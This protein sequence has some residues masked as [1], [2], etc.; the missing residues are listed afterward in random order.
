MPLTKEQQIIADFYETAGAAIK[1]HL[2]DIIDGPLVHNFIL[3]PTPGAKAIT[4]I[5]AVYE[6]NYIYSYGNQQIIVQIP[7][8]TRQT[9]FL[10]NLLKSKE[11]KNTDATLAIILGTDTFGNITIKDLREIPHVL[12]AGRTGSGKSVFLNCVLK[13]LKTAMPASECKFIIIDPKGVDYD[14]WESDKHL[15]CPIVKLDAKLAVQK[16]RE[17]SELIKE[18][19]QKLQDRKVKNI[20]EYK[21]KTKN[22]DM[23]YV[24][25]IIDE[26]ADLM[27]VA[28]KEV[29]GLVQYITQTSR[30]VGVH[31]I[32]G[33]Q[34]YDGKTL[35]GIIK[36]ILPTIIAFH[37]R[38]SAESRQILGERGAENLL[39]C[40]D[41][42]FS[43]AGRRPVRIHTPYIKH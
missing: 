37:T 31:L 15:M 4:I 2:I 13:S 7:K 27:T 41:M 18:R 9:I 30:A 40:A 29:E 25:V 42:L 3:Q 36:A 34:H 8:E 6:N 11:F 32:I 35:P 5:K 12:V 33:T 24:V 17:V 16:L 20:E 43:D 22:S 1:G 28:R 10:E 21:K 19:H 23:P 38:T 26:F 14:I 39:P